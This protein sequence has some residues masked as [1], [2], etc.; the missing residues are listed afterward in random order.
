[1]AGFEG[2]ITSDAFL[3]GQLNIKQPKGGYRA[4]TD[5]VFLAA[6][7]PAQPGDSVLDMGCG[8]GTAGLCLARRVPITLKGLE[9]QAVY[10][11]LAR[12]NAA[13]NGIE[14]DVIEGDLA[15]MPTSLRSKNFDHVIMNPPFFTHGTEAEDAGRARARQEVTELQTWIDAGLRR[16]KPKGW[17]TLILTIERLSEVIVA[18]DGRAASLQIKPLASRQNRPAGRF[19]LRA[20]KGSRGSTVLSNP[21][22]LH[23]GSSHDGDRESYTKEVSSILRNAQVI[24]F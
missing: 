3:G 6:A 8:V 5:P 20:R 1:V 14:M 12:H 15:D 23:E 9:I 21:L 22:I 24:K 17:L 10:A 2:Q 16:I 4:A 11:R 13:D 19:L 7:C 18:L